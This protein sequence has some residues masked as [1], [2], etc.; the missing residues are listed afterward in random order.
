MC[1][2]R[3]NHALSVVS[4]RLSTSIAQFVIEPALPSSSGVNVC[5]PRQF[6]ANETVSP[7]LFRSFLGGARGCL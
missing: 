6:A 5:P 1:G 2:S 3:G 7:Q 4:A